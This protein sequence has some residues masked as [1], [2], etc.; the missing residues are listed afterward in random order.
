[1]NEAKK[2]FLNS[3]WNL[4]F[5]DPD[6]KNVIETTIDVPSNV[7]P[8][9]QKLGLIADYMPADSTEAVAK[10]QLVD[11]WTYTISFD[12]PDF[13]ESW[14][15]ELVFEGI[16][17]IAQVYLNGE[18]VLDTDNMHYTY[19]VDVE[20]RLKEKENE[21]KVVIRSAELWAR[22]RLHDAYA[23]YSANAAT[24]SYLRKSRHQWGWDNAPCLLTSGI[25][26][27]VYIEA[28]PP[29]RFDEVYVYTG[30]VTDEKVRIGVMWKY[31]TETPYIRDCS[32][33]AYILDGDSVVMQKRENNIWFTQ[34]EM[35]LRLTRD[36]VELWWPT[37]FGEPK[38]YKLRLEMEKDGEIIADYET[39]FGIRTLRLERTEDILADGTGEF[40]FKVNGEKVFARGTNW[41]PLRAL[42]SQAD[43][44][45][46]TLRA[47]EEAKALNCNMIRIWGGGIYEGKE[48]FDW[49]DRN[50]IMVW[51][52]FMFACEIPP[53]DDDFCARVA[54]EAEQIIKKQ[55]NH[56]S[57]A[58]WCGDN[59]DD[60]FFNGFNAN[61][62]SL[63]SEIMKVSRVTLK[64]AVRQFDPYRSYVESS[65]FVSDN[66]VRETQNKIK[67]K[68]Y[69]LPED[70][71]YPQISLQRKVLRESKSF[72]IG[73]T[74]PIGTNAITANGEIF[75]REKS[76]AERLW[77]KPGTGGKWIHQ[78][79]GY[80]VSWRNAGKDAC[81]WR[82]GRD[83]SF[84]EWKDF[85]LALN[86]I[87]ADVFK[88][89]IEYCRVQRWTK[90]GV[91]WWSLMDMWPMLFN[92]S[93]MDWE[94][95]RK[96]P[97]YWIRQSQQEFALMAVRKETDGELGL[98]AANDTL[99]ACTAEYSVT[100]YDTEGNGRVI[101][102]GIC[103][104]APNSSELIQRIAE[105]GPEMWIIK[106]NYGGNT[107]YNHV[108]TADADFDTTRRWVEILGKECGFYDDILELK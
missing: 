94:Y 55:R 56:P 38:L 16:D 102:T 35:K 79:D 63:P 47:L 31:K 1:M 33:N 34:G 29:C 53:M 61:T 73:E 59:E 49:C 15:K 89:I 9:L 12:K 97:W 80:F 101:A 21:L 66:F 28:L 57:L 3:E 60:V 13:P 85:T 10:F 96:L 41:K 82:Y 27:P 74:G 71:M 90:T 43:A 19:R 52:D 50:G 42:C 75:D 6:T 37:G 92:Y 76:R 69:F 30:S 48:F 46:R 70:H 99:K 5:T 24:Q 26:R 65:P 20:G 88:D 64:N 103:S 18:L 72:F 91:I 100:A 4:K 67:D 98:Y 36:Q 83:F 107:C 106:W 78:L 77:D 54:L 23:Y 17:T 95:N 87:C 11:D 44:E 25:V 14:K 81:M 32:I 39:D 84:D 105:R 45:M 2:C 51:Q 40:V 22:E 108:F 8:T 58:V 86:V 93:I 68:K 62:E 104:Q 7:E